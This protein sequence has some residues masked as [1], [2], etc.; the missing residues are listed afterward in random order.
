MVIYNIF[1]IIV[2]FVG[3]KGRTGTM[4]CAWLVYNGHFDESAEVLEYFG[5]RRTDTSIGSKYQGVETPSQARYI[6]YFSQIITQLDGI[7]PENK[8]VKLETISIE[9]IVNVGHG[10][11]SDISCN[12]LIDRQHLFHFDIGTETNCSAFYN[13][14]E[15][16]LIVTPINCPILIGDVRFKFNCRSKKVPKGYEGCAFY[17][18]I[19]TSFIK[20]E[21]SISF[22][23]EVLDNPHKIKTWKIYTKKFKVTLNF[24]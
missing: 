7:I 20:N 12:I 21:K 4:I 9:G 18:W 16:I 10:D 11:G 3:G 23:R 22:D 17:F 15:D 5:D 1:P 19:N 2:L 14:N 8:S 13:R 6:D 24:A